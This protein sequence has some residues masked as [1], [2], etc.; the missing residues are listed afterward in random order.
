MSEPLVS[1]IIPCY[2]GERLVADAIESALGQTYPN[3]EVI[4]ID[5]GSTDGSL[6]VLKSFGDRIRWETGPNRGACAARNRGVELARGDVIQFLDADDLLY[7]EKIERQLAVL[8]ESK[9]RLVF[10]DAHRLGESGEELPDHVRQQSTSD[11][12]VFMLKDGLPTPA[13]LHWKENLV[14]V[15]GF[16]EDLPCS[17]ERELHLRLAAAG[18]EFIRVPE[19]LYMIR[20]QPGSLSADSLRVL[21]QHLGIVEPVFDD[22]M[23]RGKMT[24]ERARQFS[25]LLAGDARKLWN[26]GEHELARR[27]E[28][29]ARRMHPSGGIDVAYSRRTRLLRRVFGMELTERFVRWCRQL[30]SRQRDA[31]IA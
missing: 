4:V 24:P 26:C 25:G 8:L 15:G 23:Q 6:D 30:R 17:Q 10:C 12:V 1:T 22:L 20:R 29:T 13:A 7:H 27:Y 11:P 3:K 21:K 31:H 5:D 19:A 28:S 9:Q 2:N 14:R 16:R 18:L